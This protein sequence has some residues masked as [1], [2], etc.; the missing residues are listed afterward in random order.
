MIIYYSILVIFIFCSY[1][2]MR[3]F[4]KKGQIEFDEIEFDENNADKNN[5]DENITY[6]TFEENMGAGIG[7]TSAYFYALIIY[8]L[9]KKNKNKIY[10]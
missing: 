3:I 6:V 5:A 9:T 4:K 7:H 10:S 1:F 2:I 8:I